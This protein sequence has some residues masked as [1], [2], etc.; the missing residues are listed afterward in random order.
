M[1]SAYQLNTGDATQIVHVNT[2]DSDHVTI[3]PVEPWDSNTGGV[4][5]SYSRISF[6]LNKYLGGSLQ[7][8]Q[9]ERV[10]I[11]VTNARFPFTFPTMD[12]RNNDIWV[13]WTGANAPAT[14]VRVAFKSDYT[15]AEDAGLPSAIYTWPELLSVMNQIFEEATETGDRFYGL[16]DFRFAY[17]LQQWT[18]ADTANI[19]AG[20]NNYGLG[21]HEDT[22]FFNISQNKFNT[23]TYYK[24]GGVNPG[25]VTFSFK[26]PTN[27]NAGSTT[28]YGQWGVNADT[29]IS[30]VPVESGSAL[31]FANRAVVDNSRFKSV[32]PRTDLGNRFQALQLKCDFL[33]QRSQQTNI[34]QVIPIQNERYGEIV[35]NGGAE[36]TE[37]L[38]PPGV[39]NISEIEMFITDQTAVPVNFQRRDWSLTLLFMFL[40]LPASSIPK[41]VS[42]AQMGAAH[43]K[44]QRVEMITGVPAEPADDD[45]ILEPIN[46]LFGVKNLTHLS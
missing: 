33:Q 38:L 18:G 36:G 22:G 6:N 44:R 19:G 21:F 32:Y 35:F 3:K 42:I 39:Q 30:V 12:E 20:D 17:D 7:S 41:R 40:D 4:I 5:Q 26:D 29:T 24:T 25:T 37:H 45:E 11:K 27:A 28:S 9:G 13:T 10:L 14:P 1:S 34:L 16:K 23:P 46:A 31:N 8:H 15:A 43:R 2:N